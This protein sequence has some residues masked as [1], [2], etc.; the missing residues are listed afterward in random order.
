MVST[1]TIIIVGAGLAIAA[2]LAYFTYQYTTSDTLGGQLAR[3]RLGLDETPPLRSL[4]NKEA[5]PGKPLSQQKKDPLNRL[6][7]EIIANIT[8]SKS[9]DKYIDGVLQLPNVTIPTS[10]SN[11]AYYAQDLSQEEEQYDP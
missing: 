5:D 1:R 10:R 8:G 11:A 9:Q 4:L 6:V 7:D 3:S 2:S